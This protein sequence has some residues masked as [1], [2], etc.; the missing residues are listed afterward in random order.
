MQRKLSRGTSAENSFAN[1]TITGPTFT[2]FERTSNNRL[3]SAINGSI[4]TPIR[5][6]N[7]SMD[8]HPEF[9]STGGVAM[10][11]ARLFSRLPPF[12]SCLKVFATTLLCISISYSNI[13]GGR[14]N[15]FMGQ[16]H[17]L[18]LKANV[19][20]KEDLQIGVR[21][22]AGNEDPRSLS[23]IAS[24]RGDISHSIGTTDL[25]LTAH[26][27]I[28]RDSS[29]PF[30]THSVS[31]VG[32]IRQRPNLVYAKRKPSAHRVA[33]RSYLYHNIQKSTIWMGTSI[34]ER[35]YSL[36]LPIFVEQS[37]FLNFQEGSIGAAIVFIFILVFFLILYN[38][39]TVRWRQSRSVRSNMIMI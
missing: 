20:Q 28:F 33:D 3:S 19:I 8:S 38:Y 22:N 23:Y 9:A 18:S 30:G 6:R 27:N 25:L 24:S 17:N 32:K 29:A 31:T 1:N 4:R 34:R 15:K 7:L 14:E 39:F 10:S 2:A 21:K 13:S 16:S 37:E 26:E 5:Q 35:I 12:R 11:L 36:F